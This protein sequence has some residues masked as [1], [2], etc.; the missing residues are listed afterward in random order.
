M[1]TSHDLNTVKQLYG[2]LP[3]SEDTKKVEKLCPTCKSLIVL[4]EKIRDADC[5]QFLRSGNLL[6]LPVRKEIHSILKT[7]SST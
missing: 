1:K 5:A 3:A 7:L 4:I 6:P 2:S